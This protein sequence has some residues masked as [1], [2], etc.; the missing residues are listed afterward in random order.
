MGNS[1]TSA[2]RQLQLLESWPNPLI[3]AVLSNNFPPFTWNLVNIIFIQHVLSTTLDKAL[4]GIQR[5]LGQGFL[6]QWSYSL[7]EKIRQIH[8]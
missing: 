1:L 5:W 3:P 4:W 8:K 6:P 2:S 7:V